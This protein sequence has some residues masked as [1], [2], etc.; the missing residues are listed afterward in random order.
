MSNAREIRGYYKELLADS[1]EHSRAELFLY[2]R[3][4]NP[5]TN[6]TEGM[7]NG[8]LKTLVDGDVN[9]ICVERG[10]YKLNGEVDLHNESYAR[11]LIKK[12]NEILKET[13][14]KMEKEVIVNPFQLLEA[15]ENDVSQMRI[16]EKCME[17][18]KSTIERIE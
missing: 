3:Q 12:Y 16:I 6:Y 7:L 15:G 14:D 10:V 1:E 17:T 9:Y 11:T 18:I 2:A 4:R 13:I 5:E 8:A